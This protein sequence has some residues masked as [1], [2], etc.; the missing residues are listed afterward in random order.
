M[1]DFDTK[2]TTDRSNLQMSSYGNKSDL[3]AAEKAQS[4]PLEQ[5]ARSKTGVQQSTVVKVAPARQYPA[6]KPPLM[7]A[8][9]SS[10][11]TVRF[12]NQDQA[13]VQSAK[14]IRPVVG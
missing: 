3:F 12:V 5:H 14:T 2:P 9:H 4:F 8:K 7:A 1:T 6:P 13:N 10:P 11:N